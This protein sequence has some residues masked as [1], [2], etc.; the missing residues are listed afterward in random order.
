MNLDRGELLDFLTLIV[1]SFGTEPFTLEDL[2]ETDWYK[3]HPYRV[4]KMD[5]LYLTWD[6]SADRF[7]ISKEGWNL[8]KGEK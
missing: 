5:G 2:Y 6:I 4:T 1:M 8:L 7:Y 3:E